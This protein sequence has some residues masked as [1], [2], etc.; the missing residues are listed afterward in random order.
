VK[1]QACQHRR[2]LQPTRTGG[3]QWAMRQ[4]MQDVDSDG[5]GTVE[6]Q[7]STVPYGASS[8][9][10][11]IATTSDVDRTSGSSSV[12]ALQLPKPSAVEVGGS[13]ADTDRA[14]GTQH[15][16]P[17]LSPLSTKQPSSI[18]GDELKRKGIFAPSIVAG[19][20]MNE[21]RA[22]GVQNRDPSDVD[23]DTT[24]YSPK[25]SRSGRPT[26]QLSTSSLR[27]AA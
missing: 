19:E 8:P 4:N 26:T 21:A 12:H 10:Q 22:A 2:C 17:T 23:G 27:A 14:T 6:S 7:D 9:L 18:D 5:D 1:K 11:R 25:R 13:L 3:G 20:D 15:L 16:T 24:S